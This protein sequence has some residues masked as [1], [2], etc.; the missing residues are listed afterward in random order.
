MKGLIVTLELSLM[1]LLIGT[2]GGFILGLLHTLKNRLISILILT[3][4]FL[5]RGIPLLIQ[6]FFIFLVLPL[7]GILFSAFTSAMLALSIFAGA[8]I[9]EIVRGA[10]ESVPVGQVH[11]AKALG[12]RKIKIN[13]YVVLPQAFRSMV[14]PLIAQYALLIKAT[15]LVSLVGITELLKAGREIIEREVTGFEVMILVMFIYTV[16]CLS[17]TFLSNNLQRYFNKGLT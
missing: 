11:A 13:L 1:V 6:I 9:S 17:L 15:S 16:V 4:V 5:S 10:V 2:L 8:T 3:F 12:M 14:P 7:F